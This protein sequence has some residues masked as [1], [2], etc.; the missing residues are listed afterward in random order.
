MYSLWGVDAEYF[1]I[2]ASTGQLETKAAYNYEARNWY[3]PIVRVSD[4]KDR[5]VS[6]VVGVAIIDVVE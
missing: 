6:V 1:A 3:S 5:Q 4:G 2:D